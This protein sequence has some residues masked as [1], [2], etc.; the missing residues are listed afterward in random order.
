MMMHRLPPS[1]RVH[2]HHSHSK[3]TPLCFRFAQ[4]LE[5][6]ESATGH[7]ILPIDVSRVSWWDKTYA[8]QIVL[9]YHGMKLINTLCLSHLGCFGCLA[10]KASPMSDTFSPTFSL[11]YDSA[12][13]LVSNLLYAVWILIAVHDFPFTITWFRLSHPSR[14]W[15]QWF[16]LSYFFLLNLNHVETSWFSLMRHEKPLTEERCM[17]SS[18]DIR[19]SMLH[20]TNSTQSAFAL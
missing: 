9:I 7:A 20:R 14:F 10:M 18:I 2:Y 16:F 1:S 6:E 5:I 13:K 4:S 17:H 3:A 11:K 19:I 12:P 8:L 15:V